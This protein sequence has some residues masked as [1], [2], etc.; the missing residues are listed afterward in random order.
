LTEGLP[1]VTAPDFAPQRSTFRIIAELI[2][3]T[4]L[5]AFPQSI[6]LQLVRAGLGLLDMF[7]VDLRAQTEEVEARTKGLRGFSVLNA[8]VFADRWCALGREAA[9]GDPG[10]KTQNGLAGELLI[11]F[12]ED[13]FVVSSERGSGEKS[14]K[15]R[16]ENGLIDFHLN[17]HPKTERTLAAGIDQIIYLDPPRAHINPEKIHSFHQYSVRARLC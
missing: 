13:V 10:R 16:S 11:P 17:F 6:L 12:E 7:L 8:E 9:A 14:G 5:A 3:G 15:R 2:P 4:L 1:V